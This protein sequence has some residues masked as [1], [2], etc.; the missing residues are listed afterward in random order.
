MCPPR[1]DPKIPGVLPQ[2]A[3]RGS[4]E[5]SGSSASG[6]A[7]FRHETMA[8][9]ATVGTAIRRGASVLELA[10]DFWSFD[11]KFKAL[12]VDLA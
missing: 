2:A 10:K 9:A 6:A 4:R 3:S 5:G 11:R 1:P 7:R 8:A 12:L